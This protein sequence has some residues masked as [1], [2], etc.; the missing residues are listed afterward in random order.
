V[1]AAV[2]RLVD[3]RACRRRAVNFARLYDGYQPDIAI[4]AVADAIDEILA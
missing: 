2:R 4:E 1:D 3:D